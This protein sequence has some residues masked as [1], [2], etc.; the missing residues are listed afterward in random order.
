[1][2]RFQ[3]LSFESAWF[4]VTTNGYEPISAHPK[5]SA[6]AIA[7]SAVVGS[8]SELRC[9][10]SINS[11]LLGSERDGHS[12]DGLGILRLLAD[13]GRIGGH[14]HDSAD[15]SAAPDLGLAV[16]VPSFIIYT[17]SA[18]A[19]DLLARAIS[20]WFYFGAM[21]RRAYQLAGENRRLD[22]GFRALASQ[23]AP[24]PGGGW[25]AESFQ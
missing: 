2:I 18:V 24:V 7:V 19:T 8:R 12:T 16:D 3:E 14:S 25:R 11:V 5:A 1:M 22:F 21:N 17:L 13:A 10:G 9:G 6:A 23:P 20:A 15:A 4:N